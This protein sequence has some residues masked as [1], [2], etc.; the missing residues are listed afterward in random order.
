MPIISNTIVSP[1]W[2]IER[3]C[4]LDHFNIYLERPNYFLSVITHFN[5]LRHL[6]FIFFSSKNG[7]PS[8]HNIRGELSIKSLDSYLKPDTQW[9]FLFIIFT[10]LESQMIEGASLENLGSLRFS[11]PKCCNLD[12][13]LS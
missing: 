12:S 4:F 1:I 10:K 11:E 3:I 9:V 7:Q 13:A 5:K 6:N 8:I 2:T